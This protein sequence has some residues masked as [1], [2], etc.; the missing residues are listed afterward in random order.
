MMI[1]NT[2]VLSKI[3]T[4]VLE[5]SNILVLNEFMKFSERLKIARKHAKLSQEDL[6]LAVGVTQGLISKIERGE[7]EETAAVVK[8]AKACNV[9]VEWLDEGSGEMILKSN[10]TAQSNADKLTLKNPNYASFF[11]EKTNK[12]AHQLTTNVAETSIQLKRCPLISWVKAG[13]MCD[14]GHVYNSDDAEEWLI[15][16]TPHSEKTFALSVVGDSMSPEYLEGWHI[17]V[18][19]EVQAKHN[20]DVVVIDHEGKATFKRLQITPEGNYLLAL[21]TEYPNR[22]IKVPVDSTICGVV[23]YSGKRRR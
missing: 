23:I 8:L 6:A 16:G 14:V 9:R 3:N 15:C 19:P 12:N 4:P 7:Q 13:E 21:N 10:P 5:S 2:I 22:V 11:G 1:N 17:F 20:D 18:D